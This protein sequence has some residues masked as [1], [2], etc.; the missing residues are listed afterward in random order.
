MNKYQEA[1]NLISGEVI[2]NALA[3]GDERYKELMKALDML[4]ELVDKA[5]PK[6]PRPLFLPMAYIPHKCPVCWTWVNG[7]KYKHKY[8]PYCGQRIDWRNDDE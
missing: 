5:T 3:L 2:F 1:Y 7:T 8:C 4:R 6:R